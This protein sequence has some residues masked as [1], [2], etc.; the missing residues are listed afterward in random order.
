MDFCHVVLHHHLLDFHS[1][2]YGENDGLRSHKSVRRLALNQLIFPVG[3]EVFDQVG[4]LFR[5]PLI[6]HV[7]GIIDDLQLCARDL[8]ATGDVSL[9]DLHFRGLVDKSEIEGNRFLFGP[10]VLKCEFLP[11]LCGRIAAGSGDFLQ[12]VLPVHRQVRGKADLSV[13]VGCPHLD[14]LVLFDQDF[15]V[16]GQDVF[17]CIE[18]KG[19]SLQ[20]IF[21]FRVFLCQVQGYLLA[22]VLPLLVVDDDRSVLVA[23]GKIH[24]AGFAVED[25]AVRCLFLH[26][27]IPAQGKVSQFRDACIVRGDRCDQL[28]LFE[29]IRSHPVGGFDVLRCVNLEGDGCQSP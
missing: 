3:M 23:V 21:S 6:D 8:A 4:R 12:V 13:F 14:Q 2:L 9:G 26:D 28:I 1:V 17:G 15:P 7:P 16:C 10:R 18:A 25:V 20:G 29:I 22:D 19:C 24:I 27:I 5:D 11:F